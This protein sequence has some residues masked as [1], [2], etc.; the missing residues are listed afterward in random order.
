MRDPLIAVIADT[1]RVTLTLMWL[2]SAGAKLRA[3]ALF[4]ASAQELAKPLPPRLVRRAAFLVPIIEMGLAAALLVNHWA[5]AASLVAATLL[6]LFAGVLLRAWRLGIDTSCRCFGASDDD[7]KVSGF[8]MSRAALLIVVAMAAVLTSLPGR[9]IVFASALAT[10][11]IFIVACLL[12]AGSALVSTSVW[13][14]TRVEP[15]ISRRV[16]GI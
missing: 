11:G 9:H 1:L 15:R 16:A 2:W 8:T 4:A 14:V 10:L 6:A 13:L 12:V 5:T 7:E 3:L